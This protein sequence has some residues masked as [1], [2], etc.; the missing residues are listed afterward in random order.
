MSYDRAMPSPDPAFVCALPLEARAVRRAGVG[1]VIVGGVGERRAEIATASLIERHRPS[2]VLSVGL[3][4][5]LADGPAVGDLIA[6][7]AVVAAEG[8][9][10][11]CDVVPPA[12]HRG[13]FLTASAIVACRVEKTDLHRRTGAV[14]VDMESAGVARACRDRGV[15]FGVLRAVSDAAADDLPPGLAP[16]LRIAAGVSFAG[17]GAALAAV[18]REPSLVGALWRLHRRAAFAAG[19]LGDAVRLV[20]KGMT[21]QGAKSGAVQRTA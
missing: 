2:A 1:R 16:F 9:E 8:E 6:G 17:L 3:C 21:N 4:G 5:A 7:T 19:R 12:D 11:R 20:D 13:P 15:P 14:A 10:F 18:V